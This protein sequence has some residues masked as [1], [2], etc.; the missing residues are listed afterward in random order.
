MGDVHVGVGWWE[1]S[2]EGGAAGLW[3]VSCVIKQ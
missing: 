3:A 1:T 2:G